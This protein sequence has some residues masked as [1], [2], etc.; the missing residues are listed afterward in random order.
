MAIKHIFKCDKC[1]AEQSTP[2]Q[3]WTIGVFATLHSQGIRNPS[4]TVK[5]KAIQVCRNCLEAFGIHRQASNPA[6]LTPM[7]TIEDLVRQIIALA[8]E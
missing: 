3:F 8:Q 5:D 2:E 6:A 4:E 1:G 7:P